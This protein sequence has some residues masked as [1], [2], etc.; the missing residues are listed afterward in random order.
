MPLPRAEQRPT[1]E[2]TGKRGTDAGVFHC[3]PDEDVPGGSRKRL[4]YKGPIGLFAECRAAK[5][6]SP[7]WRRIT[8]AAD[9]L[10]DEAA[11]D[12]ERARGGLSGLGRAGVDIAEKA[13]ELGFDTAVGAMTGGGSTTARFRTLAPQLA[14]MF[15]AAAQEARRDGADLDQQMLYGSTMGGLEVLPSVIFNSLK[16]VFDRSTANKITDEVVGKLITSPSTVAVL[17]I[18]TMG[19]GGAAEMWI[20]KK[21]EPIVKSLYQETMLDPADIVKGNMNTF[22]SSEL[23]YEAFVGFALGMLEGGGEAV[24]NHSR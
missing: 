22:D 9:R 2:K 23:L 13:I 12:L 14:R 11:R 1:Q 15:G 8:D 7:V 16:D 10:G 18:L 3:T 5:A 17:Q 6:G 24:K 21:L 19:V 4:P 20:S